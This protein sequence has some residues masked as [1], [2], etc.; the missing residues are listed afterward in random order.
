MSWEVVFRGGE[1]P[2]AAREALVG[3]GITFIGG[4]G[5]PGGWTWRCWL[6]ASDK[7]D[8]RSTV[9][10]VLSTY[11][12]WVVVEARR[13]P[14]TVY[15]R[16]PIDDADAVEEAIEALRD[17][18][19]SGVFRTESEEG[20]TAEIAIEV[21]A[22]DDEAAWE[23]AVEIYDRLYDEVR[24][25]SGLEP[26]E[27]E[28][29]VIP[30]PLVQTVEPRYAQLLRRAR[31]LAESGSYDLSVVC[32]Q[33]ACEVFVAA[34]IDELQRRWVTGPLREVM[35]RLAGSY[36]MLGDKNASQLWRTLTNTKLAASMGEDWKSYVAHV[37]RR[38]G[39]VHA[40]E[41]VSQSKAEESIQAAER[42]IEAVREA[43]QNAP[44]PS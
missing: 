35:P 27:A 32:A 37:E 29:V 22:D 12:T 8:A 18:R 17:Q 14:H 28:G 5:G 10:N 6:L 36:T 4:H 11:G 24:A 38:H 20:L 26:A 19:V 31:D 44:A 15:L 41:S 1:L 7:E 42:F 25:D 16:V 23:Q 40:G 3:V 13:L 39:V 9:A 43:W 2:E 34:A 30:P 33:T 21:I